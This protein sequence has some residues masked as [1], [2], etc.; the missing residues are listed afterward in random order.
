MARIGP[1]SQLST[2]KEAFG[3]DSNQKNFPSTALNELRKKKNFQDYEESRSRKV[4][5]FRLSRVS[6]IITKITR[7]KLSSML[8]YCL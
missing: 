5:Q 7:C 2:P 6:R 4:D 1:P 3:R 8:C